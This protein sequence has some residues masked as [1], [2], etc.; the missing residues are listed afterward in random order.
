[1]KDNDLPHNEDVRGAKAA[2]R[3][4]ACE[5]DDDER[6]ADVRSGGTLAMGPLQLFSFART[7]ILF[8]LVVREQT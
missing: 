5:Q 6:G 1:M 8:V 2:S 3:K 4:A 7:E